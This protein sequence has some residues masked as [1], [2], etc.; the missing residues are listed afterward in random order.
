VLETA[1]SIEPETVIVFCYKDGL[2]SVL[3]S[4]CIEVMQVIGALEAAKMSIWGGGMVGE[5]EE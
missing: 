3:A 1:L 5:Y 4:E 2:I